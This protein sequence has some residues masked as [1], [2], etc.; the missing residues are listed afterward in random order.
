MERTEMSDSATSGGVSSQINAIS[1]PEV[2][3]VLGR[4]LAYVRD[5]SFDMAAANARV[6]AVEARVNP[7]VV[8]PCAV[9]G[10][11]ICGSWSVA[12]G[13]GFAHKD[14]VPA[15]PAP[16]DAQA[17]D[18]HGKTVFADAEL[19]EEMRL[20]MNSTD[21]REDLYL[22]RNLMSRAHDRLTRRAE[23]PEPASP[24]A[25]VALVVEGIK[26]RLCALG[27]YDKAAQM[28]D[29]LEQIRADLHS[30][31]GEKGPMPDGPLS[32]LLDSEIER[33]APPATPPDGGE[34]MAARLTEKINGPMETVAELRRD[35]AAA[36]RA[37]RGEQAGE[38]VRLREFA[39]D[40]AEQDCAYPN[41]PC[42]AV[43]ISKLGHGVCV[44][45]KARTA[46]DAAKQAE[47]GGGTQ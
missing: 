17:K 10:K 15:S 3:N 38:V 46:L 29:T 23:V 4:L 47:G 5:V 20:W 41:D 35:I 31:G 7:D 37:A 25:A 30:L 13:D 45:C 22:A 18:N 16:A 39:E 40:M 24:L 19:V 27:E 33:L 26:D 11:E 28:R 6:A 8:H 21:E 36:L 42:L 32:A 44:G 43:H 1:D 34:A 9:C 12:H 14:C 2:R